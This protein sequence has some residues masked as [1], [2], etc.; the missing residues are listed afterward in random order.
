MQ[1]RTWRPRPLLLALFAGIA[2]AA[3]G[4]ADPASGGPTVYLPNDSG[5]VVV[6]A[7]THQRIGR[8]AGTDTSHGLAITPDGLTLVAGSLLARAPGSP[9]PRPSGVSEADHQAHHGTAATPAPGA[10]VGTLYLIDVDRGEVARRIEVPGAIHHTLVTPDGRHAV[11]THP[12]LGGVSV[13]E[14]ASGNLIVQVAT[15][16]APDYLVGRGDGGRL[17]VSNSGAGTVSEIDP[18]SWQVTRQLDVGGAPGHLALAADAATLYVVDVVAGQVAALDL[19][20]GR[21]TQRYPAGSEPHGVALSEDGGRLYVSSLQEH[22]LSA[23]DLTTGAVA[24]RT[25]DPAPYHL[26]TVPGSG[27]LYVSSRAVPR[28]WVVDQKSLHVDSVLA[29]EGVTHQM[30]VRTNPPQTQ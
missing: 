1:Y 8:I 19:A 28:V 14:L 27:K 9:P 16:A 22:R 21:V 6:D 3:A 17:Y 11:S 25:L 30:V 10:V 4:A 18:A 23:V 29:T 7:G 5:I 12:G 24:T 20:T 26:T 15:G 13:V 2:P